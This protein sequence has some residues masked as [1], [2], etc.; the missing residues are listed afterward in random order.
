MSQLKKRKI[1]EYKAAVSIGY[2][3]RTNVLGRYA[4]L[5]NEARS[6]SK[7]GNV[8]DASSYQLFLKTFLMNIIF[9]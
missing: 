9:P 1:N 2:R 6:G 4:A 3:S 7:R 5:N 8:R